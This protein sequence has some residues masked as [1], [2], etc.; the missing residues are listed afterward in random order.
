MRTTKLNDVLFF[1]PGDLHK[2]TLEKL[3]KILGFEL[4]KPE[5]VKFSY[6]DNRIFNEIYELEITA[7]ILYEQISERF[8]DILGENVE[9]FKELAREEEMHAKLV[10]KYVDRTL[11]IV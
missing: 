7:K 8:A 10:E 11:R 6:D 5:E 3:A 2:I 4:S 9:I 1:C